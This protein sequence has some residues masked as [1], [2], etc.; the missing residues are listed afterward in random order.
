[1]ALVV[2]L[3]GVNVGGHKT[4]R[5][6]ALARELA[7]YD[8]VNIGAAGTF[9]VCKPPGRAELRAQ[10]LRKLPFAAEIAMCEG[11]DLLRL[12]RQNPFGSETAA[13]GVVRFASILVSPRSAALKLPLCIPGE[14]DWLVKVMAR[15]GCIVW[16]EYRRHMKT[17]AYLAQMDKLLGTTVTTRNWNTITAIAEVLK[18]E[19]RPKKR[20]AAASA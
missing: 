20:R 16:G 18:G 10:L 14:G 13:A 11:R 8:V 2:F 6:S 5:P 1:M 7:R 15:Q 19:S 9:V 4:L 3:R 12:A 17:I